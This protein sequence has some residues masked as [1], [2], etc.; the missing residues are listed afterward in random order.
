MSW[1]AKFLCTSMAHSPDTNLTF[2]ESRAFQGYFLYDPKKKRG[3]F[4]TFTSNLPN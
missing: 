2:G 3:N 1:I 4:L